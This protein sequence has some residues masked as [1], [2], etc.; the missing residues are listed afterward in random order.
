MARW[1]T[2]SAAA[3]Y[4]SI[5][6]GD[7]VSTS[8]MLSKPWPMSSEGKSSVGSK[9]TPTRSRIVLRYSVRF[10][11]RI[12]TR[13]GSGLA[14][15]AAR[16]NAPRTARR[17]ASRSSA[18]GCGKSSGGMPPVST[19]PITI[20]QR[21]RWLTTDASSRNSAN[22]KPASGCEPLWQSRQC[23]L[24]NVTPTS[25]KLEAG[26]ASAAGIAGENPKPAKVNA[27]TRGTVAS[28]NGVTLRRGLFGAVIVLPC[29]MIPQRRYEHTT[30]ALASAS[31]RL[32][33]SPRSRRPGGIAAE[34]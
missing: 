19:I 10:N 14:S 2:L 29:G 32:S 9:S 8:P 18:V 24:M 3:R 13:P 23:F 27:N 5:S 33:C 16:S 12:V 4:R 6:T 1:T 28:G 7:I 17:K 31:G 26:G 30:I 21:S 11:R 20:F 15:R 22:D 34:L 25:A